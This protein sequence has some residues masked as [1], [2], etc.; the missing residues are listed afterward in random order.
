MSASL[1]P[2]GSR[3]GHAIL[4][5]SRRWFPPTFPGCR[6]LP[7]AELALRTVEEGGKLWL[8]VPDDEGIFQEAHRQKNWWLATD[9]Q[10]YLDLQRTGLRSVPNRRRPCVSGEGFCRA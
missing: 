1:S 4:T 2:S 5:R 10:I 3:A 8:Y 9:A 7:R 6:S